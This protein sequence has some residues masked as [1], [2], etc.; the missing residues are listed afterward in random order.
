MKTISPLFLLQKKI[1]QENSVVALS[2]HRVDAHPARR[3]LTDTGATAQ[4]APAQCLK[5][6][7]LR[8]QLKQQRKERK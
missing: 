4:H 5:C 2:V 3:H 6:K 7:G 1:W 8:S